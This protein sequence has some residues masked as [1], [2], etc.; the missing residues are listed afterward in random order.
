MSV[1][2]T[3]IYLDA[4]KDPMVGPADYSRRLRGSVGSGD[5]RER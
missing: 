5:R 4:M 2:A 1:F 3:L